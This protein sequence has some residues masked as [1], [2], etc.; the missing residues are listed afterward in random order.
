[1]ERIIKNKSSAGGGVPILD[2]NKLGESETK[3]LKTWR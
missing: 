1:L 3:E 2:P